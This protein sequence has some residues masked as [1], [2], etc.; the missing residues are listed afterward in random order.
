MKFLYHKNEFVTDFQK[1]AKFF[2]SVF[3]D[4]CSVISN[5]NEL[6]SKF[7][8]LAQ[9]RLSSITFSTDDIAKIIQNLS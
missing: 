4:Q 9:S 8:Y 1:N 6:P 5:R 2:N 3:V 7:E